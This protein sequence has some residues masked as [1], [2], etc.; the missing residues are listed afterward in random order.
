MSRPLSRIRC[1]SRLGLVSL[2]AATL[3]VACLPCHGARGDGGE[4]A[5]LLTDLTVESAVA[6]SVAG[7][8][9]MPAF[10]VAYSID[11]L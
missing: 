10:R 4:G 11:E 2:L 1:R 3:G 7:R 8:N 9:N 5:S 6:V